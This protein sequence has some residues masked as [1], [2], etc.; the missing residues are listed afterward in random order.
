ML[1]GSLRNTGIHACGVIITPSDISEFVPITKA[2]DS[3]FYV[4][5]FDNSVVEDAGLLKMDFLGL[6]TLTIIKDTVKLIKYKYDEQ[7]YPEKFQLDDKKTYE[8]FQKGETVGIFQYE[9]P[10]MQKYL[11]ELKPSDFNDLIAMNALYRPGP[12]E[13]IPSFIA[14]KHGSEPIAYDLPE[15]EEF[16]KETYGITV[17]QEQVMLLSQKLQIFQKVKQTC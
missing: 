10:G 17:Y 16:L 13:Y 2:K 12:L 9:S 15:M 5:Q 8:L 14:R 7:L 1:E 11:K 3:D 4:T 6:K